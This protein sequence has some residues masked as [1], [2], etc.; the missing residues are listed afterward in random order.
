MIFYSN[1]GLFTSPKS[2]RLQGEFDALMGLFDCVSLQTN[3]KKTMH[4][5]CWTCHTSQAFS[6]YAYTWQVT[7]IELTYMERMQHRVHCLERGVSLAAG[8]LTAHRQQQHGF[9]LGEATIPPLLREVQGEVE[10]RV[11]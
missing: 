1:D 9:G 10:E 8:L 3:E 5:E 11:R 4:M 6:M 2:A 7:G